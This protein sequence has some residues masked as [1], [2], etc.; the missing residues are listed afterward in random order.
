M[1]AAR[2]SRSGPFTRY[3]GTDTWRYCPPR[4][5]MSTLAP[6]V[7]LRRT[8]TIQYGG[9]SLSTVISLPV[10]AHGGADGAHRPG[11][12]PARRGGGDGQRPQRGPVVGDDQH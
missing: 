3:G 10:T 5:R 9:P 2:R 1:S 12:D 7:R 4:F 6:P 8:H 11:H